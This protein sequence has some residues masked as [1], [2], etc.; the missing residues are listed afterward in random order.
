[1]KLLVISAA[2]PPFRAGEADHALHLCTE[3]AGSGVEVHVL[4]TKGNRA[5]RG[6]PFTLWP[7]MRD[8][9]WLDLPR[10]VRFIRQCG[11]DAVMLMYTGWVYNDHPMITFVPTIARRLLPKVRFVTQMETGFGSSWSGFGPRVLRKVAQHW[12]RPRG[13]DYSFGTLLRDSHRLVVLSELHSAYFAALLPEARDRIRVIPPPPLMKMCP[14]GPVVRERA[15]ASLGATH[16]EFLLA[17]FGYIDRNKGIEIL[18][19]AVEIVSRQ[20]GNVR[21]VM[22]G[23][24]LRTAQGGSTDRD[25]GIVR[26]E[27]EMLAL[28]KQAGIDDKV[29]WTPGYAPNSDEGSR[30]LRAA[31]AA[32]LP[33]VAGVTLNR[34]SFAAAAAH[35]LPIITTRGPHLEPPFRD[36]E[37]VLLCPPNDAESL[38]VAIQSLIHDATLRERLRGGAVRLAREWFSWESTLERTL[39]ALRGGNSHGCGATR[40]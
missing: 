12:A 5:P 15:R 22:V 39:G 6:S 2:F 20:G 26:Y 27:Q 25:E 32:V 1:M 35:G 13:V 37:N 34:S 11:P 7:I 4:T 31:D 23:G 36:R 38:A 19:K 8:W 14:G 9:S 29:T 24:G 18:F 33:F 40:A 17:F 16:T 21:L 10:L 28:P 3:L 30:Y